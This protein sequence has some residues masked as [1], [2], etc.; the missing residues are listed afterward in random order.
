[1][2][3]VKLSDLR[4]IYDDH[5]LKEAHR[6]IKDKNYCSI[7]LGMYKYEGPEDILFP[8]TIPSFVKD[9]LTKFFFFMVLVKYYDELFD[10]TSRVKGK[11]TFLSF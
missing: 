2:N 11:I 4:K 5:S 6:V 3:Y 9:D 10:I 7:V 8:K 1:M